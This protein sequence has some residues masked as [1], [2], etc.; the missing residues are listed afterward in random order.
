M[1]NSQ[2]SIDNLHGLKIDFITLVM[3]DF[4]CVKDTTLQLQ[5][6]FDIKCIE[7]A[8][9]EILNNTEKS[10]E[11]QE[12]NGKVFYR[13]YFKRGMKEEKHLMLFPSEKSIQLLQYL[14]ENQLDL[15][16]L[17]CHVSRVDCKYI[18]PLTASIGAK[19][20]YRHVG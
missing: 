18:Y 20:W 4:A 6:F 13:K 7:G 17:N 9:E 5:P 2:L 3:K 8:N 14:S 10:E 15:K 19:K 1:N 16:K 12:T 11:N